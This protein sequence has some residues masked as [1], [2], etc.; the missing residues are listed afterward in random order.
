MRNKSKFSY[1]MIK[2]KNDL[3]DYR[4]QNYYMHLFKTSF[5]IGMKIFICKYLGK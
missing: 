5:V 1:H 4:K 3:K 2:D